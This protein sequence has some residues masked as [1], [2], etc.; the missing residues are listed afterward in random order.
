[1]LE[2]GGL[3]VP[4]QARWLQAPG[5]MTQDSAALLCPCGWSGKETEMEPQD[6]PSSATRTGISAVTPHLAF[7]FLMQWLGCSLCDCFQF[8]GSTGTE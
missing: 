8:C 5:Q 4:L 2:P 7:R 6:W 1:M 3:L